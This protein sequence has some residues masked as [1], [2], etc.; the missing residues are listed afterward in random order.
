VPAV[1]KLSFLSVL[2]VGCLLTG[3]M[4]Q[5]ADPAAQPM[6]LSA[7]MDTSI[8]PGDDFYAYANG[9]WL[10]ATSIP[11]DRSSFGA[12][13]QLRDLSQQRVADLIRETA[14]SAPATG[15]AARQVADYYTSVMD[16]IAIEKKGLSPLQPTLRQIHAIADRRNLARYLGTTLRADIDILNTAALYTDHLFG[17]WVTQ[18]LDDPLHY[19]P[20]L[21]QGGLGM[22]DR[23]YYV[24]DSPHMRDLQRQYKSYI[25][26]LLR[27]SGVSADDADAQ[28]GRIYDLERRIAEV[29]VSRADLDDVQRGHNHWSK[30][31][32]SSRAPG[33]DWN[34]FFTGAGLAQQ[35][36]FVVWEPTSTTGIAALVKSVPVSTWKEYLTFHAIDHYA[37]LLPKAFVDAN[38]AFH[39]TALQGTPEMPERWKRAVD[40]TNDALGDAVGQMYVKRY[41]S[42]QAKQSI[43]QL[44][45]NL[46]AAFATHIDG[47]DWMAPETRT[48]AKAKLAS[49]KVGVGYPDQWTDYS[50]LRVVAGDAYGN[51]E[52]SELFQY[53]HS[54][55]K[56]SRTQVD[57]AEWVTTPQTV[58]AFN[59]PAMNAINFPAAILQAPFFDPDRP[60]VLNYGAIGAIIGHEISHSFDD[61]GA[62][63]DAT[64]RL[65]DWWTAEDY[66]HFKASSQQLVAQYDA[67]RPFPD[68]ALNGKQTLGENIA[69]IAGLAVSYSAYRSS[70]GGTEAA[71][72]E[73]FNGDQQFFV[74]FAQ[75]WRTKYRDPMLRQLVVGDGHS[76]GQYR[77]YT[78]RNLDAWYR[79]FG[80]RPD[81]SLYLP[82]DKRVRM[83]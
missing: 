33:L 29:H 32:F 26:N 16:E 43:G 35:D 70:L 68:L 72:L 19:A 6:A 66:A 31:D 2:L 50:S 34:E 74:S 39:G 9:S 24:S 82:P 52:R 55:A 38:F 83:W 10:K 77:A 27:L 62:Q 47:L 11:A 7:G 40:R 63:F 3:A 37:G 42:P 15:S 44:V 53:R 36:R 5:A 46:I 17:L 45:Q 23:E 69:D 14:A 54:L 28:A 71:P 12:F 59:L 22:P 79:A 8:Q 60:A 81:Q 41:F 73:G 18:D 57:R 64:G 13:A 75:I 20:F 4:T 78:V 1:Q 48:Q 56:L 80:V 58:N 49:L 76:P 21:A 61:Q 51:A 25:A 67:Y 30:A 65:H